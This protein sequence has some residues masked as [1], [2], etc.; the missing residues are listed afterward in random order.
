MKK[1]NR[2]IALIVAMLMMLT[3]VSSIWAAGERVQDSILDSVV[4]ENSEEADTKQ[5]AMNVEAEGEGTVG[6]L[7]AEELQQDF[8]RSQAQAHIADLKV[9][10]QTVTVTYASDVQADL[11]AGIFTDDGKKLVASGHVLVGATDET[12]AQIEISDEMPEYFEVSAYLLDPQ[13]REPICEGYTSQYY[14]KELQDFLDKRASDFAGTGRMVYLDDSSDTDK[15]LNYAV[16]REDTVVIR[17]N[18][19]TN[20]LTTNADDSWTLDKADDEAKS[21]KAGT[22]VVYLYKTG[23]MDAIKAGKVTVNGDKVTITDGGEFDL[24]DIFEY[25]RIHTDG[26]FKVEEID[27]SVTDKDLTYEGVTYEG[28]DSA[29]EISVQ[30]DGMEAVG[31]TGDV[32]VDLA[33]L[34]FSLNATHSTWTSKGGVNAQFS[35][36]KKDVI[37]TSSKKYHKVSFDW[38]MTITLAFEGS[39][40]KELEF[41]MLKFKVKVLPLVTINIEPSVCL[42]IAGNVTVSST[43]KGNIAVQESPKGLIWCG[44]DPVIENNAYVQA[45]VFIGMKFKVGISI[46]EDSKK[47]KSSISLSVKAGGEYKVSQRIAS[48]DNPTEKKHSCATCYNIEINLKLS[49][50]ANL[51]ALEKA[52][53][54]VV[55]ATITKHEGDFFRSKDYDS[56]GEGKCPHDL[57]KTSFSVWDST[58]N[59]LVPDAA[60]KIKALEEVKQCDGK[61]TQNEWPEESQMKTDEKGEYSIYLAPGEYEVTV[62]NDDYTA[63]EKVTV[64]N[65]KEEHQIWMK[66]YSILYHIKDPENV[67]LEGAEV[68]FTKSN[69]EVFTTVSDKLGEAQMQLKGGEYKVEVHYGDLEERFTTRVTQDQNIEIKLHG[70]LRRVTVSVVDESGDPVSDVNING[71]NSSDENILEESVLTDGE[72]KAE[73]YLEDGNY[74][75]NASKEMMKGSVDVTVDGEDEEVTCILLNAVDVTF[76]A[77]DGDGN[78]VPDAQIKITGSDGEEELT[79]TTDSDGK[80]VFTLKQGSWTVTAETAELTAERTVTVNSATSQINLN[81]T[82]REFPVEIY[83][84]YT[85]Y[86]L[87]AYDT[88]AEYLDYYFDIYDERGTKLISDKKGMG[89]EN[90]ASAYQTNLKKG[91]YICILRRAE[92][93][94]SRPY[95][96]ASFDYEYS[97]EVTGSERFTFSTERPQ[98]HYKFNNGNLYIYRD[99]SDE[100]A[101][102][103]D[104]KSDEVVSVHIADSIHH[105]SAY[106]FENYSNLEE[107]TIDSASVIEDSVFAKCSS[108]KK[109]TVSGSV[110]MKNKMTGRI[111]ENVYVNTAASEAVV[112][113]NVVYSENTDTSNVVYGSSDKVESVVFGSAMVSNV[114]FA[115]CRTIKTVTLAE[116]T[117]E[118]HDRMFE[119][120]PALETVVIPSSITRIGTAAFKNCYVLETAMIPDSVANIGAE[121][122]K[123]CYVLKTVAIPDG[124]QE[125]EKETFYG[126]LAVEKVAIPG[127]VTE[128]DEAAFAGCSNLTEAVISENIMELVIGKQAFQKCAKLESI[129]LP[130]GVEELG[131]QAF[132]GCT[133]LKNMTIPASLKTIGY[134]ALAETGF[135]TMTL[136]DTVES[137]DGSIFKGCKELKKLDIECDEGAGA[138]GI[139]ALE[140][141]IINSTESGYVP[142]SV[143]KLTLGSKVKRVDTSGFEGASSLEEIIWPER[144]EYLKIRDLSGLTKLSELN[145]PEEVD[146]YV[147]NLYIEDREVKWPENL[148]VLKLPEGVKSIKYRKSALLERVRLPK[149]IEEID[150]DGC[151][152]LKGIVIP[153]SVTTMRFWDCSS[154]EYVLFS[155]ESNLEKIEGNTFNG[156]TNLKEIKLPD[157]VRTIEGYAFWNC[158]NL[159]NIQMPKNLET[160]G[161]AAFLN[162]KKIKTIQLFDKVTMI[163]DGAFE[164]CSGMENIQIPEDIESL[165]LEE[166]AFK[167]CS[168]LVSI[169]LPKGLK[170]IPESAFEDCSSLEKVDIKG[171]GLKIEREA[172]YKCTSLKNCENIIRKVSNP[173][174]WGERVFRECTGLKKVSLPAEMTE[175]PMGLFYDCKGIEELE[176]PEGITKLGYEAFRGCASLKKIVFP[177][178]LT[179]LSQAFDYCTGLETVEIAGNF[180]L[181]LYDVT[182]IFYG[183][184][185]LKTIIV[186]A[187]ADAGNYCIPFGVAETILFKPGRTGTAYWS[188]DFWAI[189]DVD[190]ENLKKITIYYP[191][192]EAEYYTKIRQEKSVKYC[193]WIPY[194]GSLD[195][196]DEMLMT[197]EQTVQADAGNDLFSDGMAVSANEQGENMSGASQEESIA[198][199]DLSEADDSNNEETIENI[200]ENSDENPFSDFSEN[201]VAEANVEVTDEN[202]PEISSMD[203]PVSRAVDVLISGSGMAALSEDGSSVDT[204]LKQTYTGL[205][206]NSQCFFALVRD[207]DAAD[208]FAP[209]NIIYMTQA[210]SDDNGELTVEY[211]AEQGVGTPILYGQEKTN[212]LSVAEVTVKEGMIYTGQEQKPSVTVVCGGETLTENKDYVLKGD[213]AVTDAGTYKIGITGRNAYKGSI[214]REYQVSRAQQELK[215]ELTLTQIMVGDK[216]AVAAE[217]ETG[218]VTY[219]SRQPEIATVDAKGVITGIKEGVASIMVTAEGDK[220]HDS[221]RKRLF[222]FV[223]TKKESGD[224]GN[225]SNDNTNGNTNGNNNSN[226]NPGNNTSNGNTDNGN[227]GNL[228]NTANSSNSGNQTSAPVKSTIKLNASSLVMQK[229]QKTSA[230]K[231][232]GMVKGDYVKS[233]VSGNKKILK[234]L[235]FTKNGT[236]SLQ[237]QNKTGKT[238]LTIKLANGAQ[239]KITVKVQAG[240]VRTSRVSAGKKITVKKG[241]KQTLKP[242]CLPITTQEKTT[243][244][245]SNK[246]IVT[247]TSKGVIKGIRPGKAKITIKSGRKKMVV[248]VT[249]TK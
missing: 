120:C 129:H 21:V 18:G 27:T 196:V 169:T 121:A 30:Q 77:K 138:F 224:N 216:T 155:G 96:G 168:S 167:S 140:E 148:R 248:T 141:L 200:E 4:T 38:Q 114:S 110:R 128:I 103:G 15:E 165:T 50:T 6:T 161:S 9:E 214:E 70:A 119:G 145:I 203:K 118:I 24:Q 32:K 94:Y 178:T 1:S 12:T 246:K 52:S 198:S 199:E 182:P 170:T 218:A 69:G 84:Q 90:P 93:N 240:K 125:I 88:G 68:T 187:D 230:L 238:T 206:E 174:D 28:A 105:I 59:E 176:I 143:K 235:K 163:G 195:D 17:E 139:P 136:P 132:L 164:N 172:F 149:G 65:K 100:S 81:M 112:G 133:S 85:K 79:G 166:E 228:T 116:G 192:E 217:A 64:K 102:T 194:S 219:A 47:L 117:T 37:Q 87:G 80:A 122:F 86:L 57:Y 244:S 78:P 23:R 89:S 106:Y 124:M 173:S 33:N 76:V 220:N 66:P 35:N 43:I 137:A 181:Y 104:Y 186:D 229:K 13:T 160:I 7:L 209:S 202:G 159:E 223:T 3:D 83:F 188:G 49:V 201:S 101:N 222:V 99:D 22:I 75:V 234:V 25:I 247:V 58:T 208:F 185:S 162:C 67:L 225:N 207:K 19:S 211:L 41:T 156:C 11:V 56:W 5:S 26:S 8:D 107:V 147:E 127:S 241:K 151:S 231:V 53:K 210:A 61:V 92:R 243:Y 46:F 134:E 204:L 72:G 239:K 45:S 245:S 249:V 158:E 213:T 177:H 60:I 14:T 152:A 95:M 212:D 34:K 55:L 16:Y 44:T 157:K 115:G 42:D 131:E 221:V 153:E 39:T 74:T 111:I 197:A 135:V 98:I 227:K 226:N 113:T 123:N 91:K 63:V 130:E 236:I 144:L 31:A 179:T 233:V 73:L 175:V 183:C 232:S 205:V 154:M 20:I 242:V 193:T 54:D 29:E 146:E 171:E 10:G 150:F 2:L 48:D 36:Y 237:A 190:M 40:G 189:D 71:K 184:S 215:A 108:L 82:A 62:S 97:F 109:L 51:L 180:G 142:P 126:C 191:Q